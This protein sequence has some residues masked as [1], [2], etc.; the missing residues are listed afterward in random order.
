MLTI[1]DE[2]ARQAKWTEILTEVHGSAINLPFSGKGNP[3]VIN[4]RLTGYTEGQQQFDYP[5]HTLSATTARSD[6]TGANSITVAP[7]SQSGLFST[8]GR[9]DPHTYRPNEFWANNWVYEGLTKCKC[10]SSLLAGWLHPC[11]QEAEQGAARQTARTASS[12]RRSRPAGPSLTSQGARPA[13]SCT[14]SHSGP[15]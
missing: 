2:A 7:A 12:S 14:R 1:S 10:I 13:T 4:K 15:A 3:T 11:R 6:G 9:V 8:V 5:L